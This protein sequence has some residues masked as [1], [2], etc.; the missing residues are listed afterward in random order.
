MF[1]ILFILLVSLSL[2]AAAALSGCHTMSGAGQDI[3]QGGKA[4]SDKADEHTD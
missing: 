4:I 3:E 2:T 1:R